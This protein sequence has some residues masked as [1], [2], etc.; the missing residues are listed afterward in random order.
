MRRHHSLRL[1]VTLALGI[2][3][4]VLSISSSA[5]G[6]AKIPTGPHGPFP[7][8]ISSVSPK[9]G[10]SDVETTVVIWG[11]NFKEG[12]TVQV[13]GIAA[14]VTVQS[15][16]LLKVV[17]PAHGV[18]VVDVVVTNAN[19]AQTSA[20]LPGIFTYYDLAATPLLV[21]T[22]PVS[23]FSTSEVHDAQEEIVRFNVVGD[24]L[25]SDDTRYFGFKFDGVDIEAQQLCSCWF[26]IRFGSRNGNRRA[27]LTATYPHEGNPGTVLDLDRTGG[28][29]TSHITHVPVSEPGPNTLSVVVTEA[30]A[31]GR[32]PVPDAG[33]FFVL[34]DG[35]RAADTDKDGRFEFRWLDN[36]SVDVVISKPGYQTVSR[37]VSVAGNTRL[38]VQMVR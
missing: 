21:F 31:V 6:E 29:I 23:G 3:L 15:P 36:V 22:D 28:W 10:P 25:W 5:C 27:Y 32:A 17:F 33:V 24:L 14:R 35:W 9:T 34:G 1:C 7:W 8:W 30:T 12:L 38:D 2:A 16:T 26:Q 11:S 20:S 37:Q 4:T 19:A 13:D 18:G